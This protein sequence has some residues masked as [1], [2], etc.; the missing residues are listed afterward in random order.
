MPGP[1]KALIR[2]ILNSSG[3]DITF[4]GKQ[5]G[6]HPGGPG[7]PVGKIDYLLQDMKVRG[8]ACKN[9]LDVGANKAWW[10]RMAKVVFP[11]ANIFMI[12]P[13][14]EMVPELESFCREY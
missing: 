14:S 10:S 12:E 5:V 7:R 9:I 13:L 4:V 6:N 11:M 3:Y 1:F 8:F 2:R